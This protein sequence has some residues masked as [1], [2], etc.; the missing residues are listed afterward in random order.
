MYLVFYLNTSFSVFDS[1]LLKAVLI[2][3][4]T[5]YY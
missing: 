1:T 5:N 2:I 3:M 4:T